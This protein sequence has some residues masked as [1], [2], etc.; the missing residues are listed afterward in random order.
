M[1]KQR[2]EWKG[3]GTRLA[4]ENPD[5]PTDREQVEAWN[6]YKKLRN[7]I[8]NR[9]KNEEKEFKKRKVLEN[10]DSPQKTWTTAKQFMEWKQQGPPQQLRC[11]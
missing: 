8:N 7:K 11:R 9:K 2:E 5:R 10:I 3:A 6:K 4:L 1:M